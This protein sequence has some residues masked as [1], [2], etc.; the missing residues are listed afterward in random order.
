MPT[1]RRN[2][3]EIGAAGLEGAL[4]LP[5]TFLILA[6]MLWGSYVAVT[7]VAMVLGVAEQARALGGASVAGT[8]ALNLTPLGTGLGGSI[9]AGA[10]GCERNVRAVIGT[11]RV[12]D[13][14]IYGLWTI[15][16]TGSSTSRDWDF[17]A[18]PSADGCP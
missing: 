6:F 13:V 18:G 7:R 16:F 2:V 15:P 12:V 5:L 10:A 8:N 4:T 3:W 17:Q 1:K 9:V 14:P 11:T